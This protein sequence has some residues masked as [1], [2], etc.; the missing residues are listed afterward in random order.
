M[1]MKTETEIKKEI[2]CRKKQKRE[3]ARKLFEDIT[4]DEL[5]CSSNYVDGVWEI[6]KEED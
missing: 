3:I 4:N 6:N 2:K 5:I 1:V